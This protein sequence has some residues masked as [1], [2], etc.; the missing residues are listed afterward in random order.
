M[1]LRY[2]I[3]SALKLEH[4]IG[5]LLELGTFYDKM[6]G[7]QSFRSVVELLKGM[8]PSPQR[9]WTSPRSHPGQMPDELHAFVGSVGLAGMEGAL[10][11]VH[12][13]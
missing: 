8:S 5:N 12:G 10:W 2:G 9:W 4:F 7:G 1:V 13:V 6:D 11:A 3:K